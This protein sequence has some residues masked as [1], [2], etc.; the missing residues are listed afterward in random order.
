MQT[1]ELDILTQSISNNAR[2]L[3]LLVI[4]PYAHQST[5]I[6]APLNFKQIKEI[7]NRGNGNIALGREINELLLELISVGLLSPVSEI[8]GDESLNG[9][10][11]RLSKMVNFDDDDMH[12]VRTKMTIEWQPNEKFF[13]EIAQLVGLL[14][15]DYSAEELGEFIA[16]WMG[17]PQQQLSHWQWTQKFILHLRK[18]K[19]IKGYNPTTIVGYQQIEKQPEVVLD[20]NTRKLID[21]YHGKS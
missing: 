19:Q 12:Q 11:F 14:Q 10:Q 2:V 3:Y 6:S 7:L 20:D 9:I 18:N 17:K 15:T 5:G 8:D 21:K 1:A 13:R 4:R 16:Y